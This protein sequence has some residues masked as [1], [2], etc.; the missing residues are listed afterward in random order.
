MPPPLVS[1][2]E[3]CVGVVNGVALSCL[4]VLLLLLNDAARS[5]SGGRKLVLYTVGCVGVVESVVE[6]VVDVLSRAR[7][8]VNRCRRCLMPQPLPSV[9]V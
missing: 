1:A 5:S 9:A 4:L 3:A 6:V 7:I 8:D 2:V